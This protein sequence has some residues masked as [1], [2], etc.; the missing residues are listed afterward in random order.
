MTV[1]CSW[2]GGKES[3]LAL[4]RVLRRNQKVDYLITMFPSEGSTLGHGLPQKFY[5]MQADSIGIEMIG[6]RTD[7]EGYEE[8]LSGLIESIR[9]K[10]GIFGDVYLRGHREWVEEKAEELNFRPVEPLWGGDPEDL[11]RE[12]LGRGYSGIVVKVDPGSVPPDWLGRTLDEDF[13]NYLKDNG[14]CPLGE[15]GEFHTA[16]L[17]GPTFERRI[18]VDVGPGRERGDRLIVELE[19]FRLV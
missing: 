13:L 7:W 1:F 8:K 5:K 11:F 14:I 2:S 3:T 10:E 15:R 6:E 9:A 18:E 12:Y 19:S 17:D 4:D 16:T